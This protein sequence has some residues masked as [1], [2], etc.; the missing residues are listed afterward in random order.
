MA[1]LSL[2]LVATMA[3]LGLV[4]ASSM[5][6]ME[7]R[8]EFAATTSFAKGTSS[9]KLAGR[10][11]PDDIIPL[12]FAVRQN[13]A[14][15]KAELAQISD[16]THPRY[17]QYYTLEELAKFT[18][19]ESTEALHAYLSQF[20][21]QYIDTTPNGEYVKV[22]V[23][24]AT[25]N[26]MLNADYM[27]FLPRDAASTLPAVHRT[28]RYSLPI[29]VA[30]HL[31][32]VAYTT[33]LPAARA[34]GVFTT[35]E[36][37][38]ADADGIAT[39]SV[40]SK[41]YNIQN[42][43]CATRSSSNAVFETI[44]QS[45]EPSDLTTF[46]KNYGVPAQKISKVVGT[47]N[48]GSC[49]NPNNCVEAELDVQLITAIAQDT[50]TTFWSI[51]GSESFVEWAK[52]V[53]AD[54]NP[55]KVHSVSYG[56]PE[57]ENPATNVKSF[58]TEAMKLGLRG[59][60]IMVAS[61]DDGVAGEGARGNPSGCGFNPSYPATPPHV[62]AVGA[63]QGPESGMPEIAC[64]SK[65]GGGITTGGGFSVVFPRPSYQ[66][67]AVSAYLKNGP[68]MPPAS[69]YNG[70]GRGYPDVAIMGHNYPIVVG[71]NTYQGS[72]TSA[73]SPVFAGMITLIN[74]ERI[75]AGKKTLGFLNTALYQ[76]DESVFHDITS[77][78]NNCAAGQ[79]GSQTCCQYGFTA[80]TGWDPLTGRG[81]PR[82]EKFKAALMALP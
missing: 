65:T 49:V 20:D 74:A 57:S 73:A 7:L 79:Q 47:N 56:S 67:A 8:A 5:L 81:S 54:P 35:L 22:A 17:A 58:D 14:A 40:I 59:V 26:A 78:E 50:A 69:K 10:S 15:L 18:F 25:A 31:D 77:G 70:A 27:T 75:Q 71:G 37:M 6:D 28:Q 61:G 9:Y 39:I 41:Y 76:L 3:V 66:D 51:P 60:T 62:T 34:S 32:Y 11:S 12:I 48:P 45:Y 46:D 55:P 64:S 24:V 52:A 68:N 1:R 38:A 23:T 43:T 80:T 53:A 63:T 16:P 44:G 72:G 19:P 4:A 21:L 33:N 13:T 30:D 36:P 2:A 42:L 29:S 82:F